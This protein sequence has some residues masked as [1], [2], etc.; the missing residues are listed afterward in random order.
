MS[1]LLSMKFRYL[2]VCVCVWVCV[3]VCGCVC[4]CVR[5]C[6][7]PNHFNKA[8]AIMQPPLYSNVRTAAMFGSPPQG[9]LSSLSAQ[10]EGYVQPS[11][12]Y[13]TLHPRM[14]RT[15]CRGPRW[16]EAHTGLTCAPV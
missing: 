11:C 10:H 13:R 6:M 7:M 4:V 15:L 12:T 2:C 16:G 5:V 8:F 3:G 14:L 9:S 1:V